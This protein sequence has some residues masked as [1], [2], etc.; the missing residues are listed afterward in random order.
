MDDPAKPLELVPAAMSPDTPF[1]LR[2]VVGDS[3]TKPDIYVRCAVPE[4]RQDGAWDT[5]YIK[6]DGTYFL[7]CNVGDVGRTGHDYANRF[8][9]DLLVWYGKNRS[10][11]DQPAIRSMLDPTT[12]VLVF[13]R[14]KNRAPFTYLGR[15]RVVASKTALPSASSGHSTIAPFLCPK[16]SRKKSSTTRRRTSKAP[17]SELPSTPTSAT[18]ARAARASPSTAPSAPSAVFVS[19]RST[20]ASS[21]PGL[22]KCIT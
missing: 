5:G 1:E 10:R 17:S 7:F 12:P 6:F 22:S 11:S 20:A 19:T 4:A 9:G 15:A 21:V 3:Y 8:D 18:R 2:F 13:Y 14:A 16:R